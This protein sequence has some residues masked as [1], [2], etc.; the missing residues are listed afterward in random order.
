MSICKECM[1]RNELCVGFMDIDI[2]KYLDT[3][4]RLRKPYPAKII[5]GTDVFEHIRKEMKQRGVYG[6]KVNLMG[7]AV[8]LFGMDIEID[9]YCKNRIAFEGVKDFRKK[10]WISLYCDIDGGDVDG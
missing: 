5:L 8:E 7:E 3:D 10:K 2:I 4:L 1:R 9:R 6:L